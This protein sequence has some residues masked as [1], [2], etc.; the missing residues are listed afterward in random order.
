MQQTPLQL[1]GYYVKSLS[2][3]L[4]SKLEEVMEAKASPSLQHIVVQPIPVNPLTIHVE[5]SGDPKEDDFSRWRFVLA[6][7]AKNPDD[8]SYPY[9]FSVEI[10]GFFKAQ[11]SDPVGKDQSLIRTNAVAVLYSAARD[12]ISSTTARGPYPGALLP[13]ISFYESPLI[14]CKSYEGPL[15]IKSQETPLE[16]KKTRTAKRQKRRLPQKS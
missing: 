16:S 6:V 2:F 10:V 7:S 15:A 13:L 4:N 8:S 5:I 12:V 14:I 3:G 1:E 9:D 11:F